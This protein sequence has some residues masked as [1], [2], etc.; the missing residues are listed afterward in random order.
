MKTIAQSIVEKKAELTE[1][2]DTLTATV[3]K[4]EAGEDQAEV[5]DDLTVKIEKA[6]QEVERL[7]R[8]EKAMGQRAKPLDDDGAS[9]VDPKTGAVTPLLRIGKKEDPKAGTL[10]AKMGIAHAIA[11]ADR[12][13]LVEVVS[14]IYPNDKAALAI[15]KTATT[16]ADTTT[17]GW[18]A[19]L[20]R[21]EA[22]GMLQTDLVPVSVAAALA[23]QGQLLDFAG[24]QSILIPSITSRGTA[25]G[26]SWVGENGVIPVKRGTV[27]SQ[28]LNRYKLAVITTLTR[29]LMRASDPSA[30]ETIR[31]MMVQD[32]A[33][34]LDTA[35]LDSLAGVAGIRPNGL[36]F[37]VAVT[38]GAA[39][40][41]VAA[42]ATD[43]QTMYDKLLAAGLGIKP[44][45]IVNSSTIFSVSMIST[46][47]GEFPFGTV[48]AGGKLKA[49]P[50]LASPFVPADTAIMVDAAYFSAA[51]DSPEIDISEEATLTMANADGVAPTQAMSPA[52]ALGIVEQVPPDAGISVVGGISGAASAGYQAVSLFQTWSIAQRLVMP[53]GWGTTRPGAVQAVNAITW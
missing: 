6:A 51:F 2:R 43:L 26:G 18:A 27:G 44:V 34:M 11:K 15:A 22:R 45:L 12:M 49:F 28:R 35:L 17:A 36:L 30:I 4:H 13:G 7:E 39:G 24:A 1:L 14:R 20:V 32:T 37:G 25:V 16:T 5:I 19:E 40:G 9:Q 8:V 21:S 33:N 48:E 53:V 29:E 41:G 52:G 10:L 42:V 47:L 46:P 38:A 23:A 3:A 31:R 50:I